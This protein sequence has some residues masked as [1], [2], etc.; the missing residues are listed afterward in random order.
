[1]DVVER[2]TSKSIRV[3]V[4]LAV[5]SVIP[6]HGLPRVADE[7]D[8]GI[9]F[10]QVAQKS[11]RLANPAFRSAPEDPFMSLSYLKGSFEGKDVWQAPAI[12]AI[13]AQLKRPSRKRA[14]RTPKATP[15]SPQQA[16]RSAPVNFLQLLFSKLLNRG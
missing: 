6:I 12:Q 10:E 2:A 7:P 1:V 15:P 14:S 9:A 5:A 11:Y 8:S 16:E 3:V 13:D 4:L